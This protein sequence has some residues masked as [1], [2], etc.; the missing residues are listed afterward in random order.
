MDE[1]TEEFRKIEAMFLEYAESKGGSVSMEEFT[2]LL[3][4]IFADF[5][6]RLKNLE[7]KCGIERTHESN[8]ANDG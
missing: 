6:L 1:A 3:I 2:T 8:G 7:K 4:G 5:S